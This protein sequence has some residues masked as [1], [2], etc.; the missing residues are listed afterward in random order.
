MP[1]QIQPA[2]DRFAARRDRIPLF[3]PNDRPGTR[4][5]AV[6][7]LL[8]AGFVPPDIVVSRESIFCPAMREKNPAGF[9]SSI[10]SSHLQPEEDSA[11]PQRSLGMPRLVHHDAKEP[12]RI[13]PQDKPVFVCMCGLSKNLPFCD[14]AHKACHAEKAGV[15]SVYD[16]DREKVV[17]ERDDS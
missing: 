15:V 6:C 17:E 11:F 8:F 2:T 3:A 14:G 1:V 4:P 16:R 13:D 10:L 9:S 5:P 7:R 12:Y